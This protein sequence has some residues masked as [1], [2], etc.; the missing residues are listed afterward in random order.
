M[1]R[2]EF[3][4]LSM[5]I[6]NHFISLRYLRYLHGVGRYATGLSC[7]SR[8]LEWKLQTRGE[9]L[10]NLKWDWSLRLGPLVAVHNSHPLLVV[11]SCLRLPNCSLMSQ[12]E[13]PEVY[14]HITCSGFNRRS[15]QSTENLDE[16]KENTLVW[17]LWIQS[18]SKQSFMHKICESLL[19][20][21]SARILSKN[22]KDDS[23]TVSNEI[24][25][26]HHHA[27]YVCN[28]MRCAEK[29]ITGVQDC[30]QLEAWVIFVCSSTINGK[31]L[32]H[33]N[34]RF[35]GQGKKSKCDA[36]PKF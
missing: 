35:Y 21:L 10:K 11:F 15:H 22:I 8:F 30:K 28:P 27:K 17:K 32:F 18:T 3:Q 25:R 31:L 4:S 6:W 20:H 12:Q 1:L 13:K 16:H 29:D 7:T 34:R 19:G 14:S 33:G 26:D 5:G 9:R 24:K 23:D 36:P 2:G